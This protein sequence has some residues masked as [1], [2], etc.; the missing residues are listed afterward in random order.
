MFSLIFITDTLTYNT[1]MYG[2]LS[3]KMTKPCAVAV[4]TVA[5]AHFWRI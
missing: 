2:L 5:A 3:L 1:V 4:C